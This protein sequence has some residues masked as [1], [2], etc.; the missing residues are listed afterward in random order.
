VSGRAALAVPAAAGRASATRAT[1]RNNAFIVP[2][3]GLRLPQRLTFEQWLK[4]GNQL[5]SLT[6]ST[7]WCLGDWLVYGEKA[8]TGRYREAI[9][10]TSLD[11]QTLRNYAW[12]AKQVPLSRR[13][14]RLSFSH[15]A[16][17]AALSEPEQDF[18]LRTAEELAWTRNRLRREVQESLRERGQVP[19]ARYEVQAHPSAAE[20]TAEQMTPAAGDPARFTLE[21]HIP[22]AQVGILQA[23]AGARGLD[24]EAWALRILE[25][26]ARD[27]LDLAMSW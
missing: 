4:I 12:V 25:A 7:A 1:P 17:V 18:W 5:A 11:Y 27:A 10:Q 14:D 6:T 3:T 20:P 26:A 19:A 16:E 15:H 24:L 22:V 21:V 8:F 13:R 2:R 9:A 23:A